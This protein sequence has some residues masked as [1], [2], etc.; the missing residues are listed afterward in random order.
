MFI[1]TIAPDE[2]TGEIAALYDAE[3]KSMGRV[4][5]ATQCWS[6]RPM[7]SFRLKPYCIRYETA[8]H[9]VC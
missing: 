9:L 1:K 5:Q 2:A 7:S 4:M 8:F 6:A 3:R